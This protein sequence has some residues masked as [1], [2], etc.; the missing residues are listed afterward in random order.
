LILAAR[1]FSR[2]A[3]AM[4]SHKGWLVCDAEQE[5]GPAMLLLDFPT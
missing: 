3:A 1:S 4:T 2:N 5:E